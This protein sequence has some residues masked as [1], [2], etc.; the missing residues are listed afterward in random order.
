MATLMETSGI[1]QLSG[2][3]FFKRAILF[4]VLFLTSAFAFAQK[5]PDTLE[6]KQYINRQ[7]LF[8][9]I[10]EKFDFVE[11]TFLDYYGAD[12]LDPDSYNIVSCDMLWRPIQIWGSSMDMAGF[13][14]T[15]EG[16]FLA[17]MK[18]FETKHILGFEL[19]DGEGMMQV[20]EYFGQPDDRPYLSRKNTYY[21]EPFDLY[22]TFYLDENSNVEAFEVGKTGW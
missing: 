6:E 13:Y 5:E 18:S 7:I 2:K 9:T 20:M 10:Q 3:R 19:E 8:D 12:F 21:N 4:M 11:E 22:I 16:Y 14:E 15:G 1:N 17:A